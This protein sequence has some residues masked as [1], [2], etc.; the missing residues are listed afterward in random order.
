MQILKD[1]EVTELL[2]APLVLTASWQDVG[3]ILNIGDITN[4][5]LWA[6]LTINSSTG[7][8]FK[9]VGFKTPTDTA[10]PYD[11][12]IHL[13]NETYVAVNPQVYKLG[14]DA[15]Q[16]I[17]LGVASVDVISFLKVQ[18]KATVVGVTPAQL[19]TCAVLAN[20]SRMGR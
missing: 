18:V 14:V 20:L 16:K 11:L 13:V 5:S 12:P 1:N 2:S 9:V 7:V 6:A 15:D 8:Q 17:I 19:V 3:A 10:N 4:L